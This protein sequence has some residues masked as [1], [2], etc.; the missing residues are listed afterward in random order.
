VTVCG[1]IAAAGRSVR[2]GRTKAL[3][4][5]GGET[6][7][8]HLS[9]VLL[10]AGLSPV[11]VT[12]PEPPEGALVRLALAKVDVVAAHN[13]TPAE[14]L[15]GSVKTALRL[16]RGT[17]ALV[18]CPVDMPFVTAQLVRRLLAALDEGA[19]AAAPWIDG[20]RGHPVALSR[21]LF[22]ELVAGPEG[23]VRAVLAAHDA[24]VARVPWGDARVL[25]NLNTPED[26]ERAFSH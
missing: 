5:L 14:G 26:F 24:E 22:D 25:E 9:R 17:S 6:F 20:Q 10:R 19:L 15:R 13:D 1:L 11:I 18:L 7:V 2:M 3:L 8:T 4:P 23:G 21:A 12:V 16:A